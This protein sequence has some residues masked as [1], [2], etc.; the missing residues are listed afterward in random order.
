MQEASARS[1]QD[2]YLPLREGYIL[3]LSVPTDFVYVILL[4]RQ[5]GAKHHAA[6]IIGVVIVVVAV[7]IDIPEIVAVI[8][9]RRTEPPPTSGC[10]EQIDRI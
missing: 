6:E 8:V 5:K 1:H 10:T 3:L 9:I 2:I 7:L 4:C